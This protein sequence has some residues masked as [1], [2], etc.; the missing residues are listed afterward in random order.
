M[1]DAQ[2][3]DPKLKSIIEVL[4]NKNEQAYSHCVRR[5]ALS[6]G[7]VLV[8]KCISTLAQNVKHTKLIRQPLRVVVPT[9]LQHEIIEYYHHNLQT[10]HGS[11]DETHE[12]IRKH[13]YWFGMRKQIKEYID[14]RKNS[15]VSL[16]NRH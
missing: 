9:S 6:A 12:R 10:S 1:R 7:G 8:Y 15:Q 3:R 4:R 2:W 14:T 13:F 16:R 11:L 5:F